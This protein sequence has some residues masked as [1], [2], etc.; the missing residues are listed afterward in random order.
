MLLVNVAL[1]CAVIWASPVVLTIL[2][3]VYIRVK[4]LLL[5]TPLSAVIANNES[6]YI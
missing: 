5:I 1:V 3:L 4:V 2:E 6:V